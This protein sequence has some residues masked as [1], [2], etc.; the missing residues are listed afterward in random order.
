MNKLGQQGTTSDN[1]VETSN[2]E[3]QLN[4]TKKRKS[5]SSSSQV[6]KRR[7]PNQKTGW[8]G[9]WWCGQLR[10]YSWRKFPQ[11]STLMRSMH[12]WFGDETPVHNEINF[13]PNREEL[14]RARMPFWDQIEKN[15]NIP[16][17]VD[18][19]RKKV[20]AFRVGA[21]MFLIW[22]P[23]LSGKPCGKPVIKFLREG[24]MYIF[25]L[26]AAGWRPLGSSSDPNPEWTPG[27][28]KH[29]HWRHAAGPV[30]DK[31]VGA[32][33]DW[34]KI[35]QPHFATYLQANPTHMAVANHSWTVTCSNS[36]EHNVQSQ[37]VGE[38]GNGFT[39]EDI[40]KL[41][42]SIPNAQVVDLSADAV[43]NAFT[44]YD[45]AGKV[46]ASKVLIVPNALAELQVDVKTL[47][48]ELSPVAVASP[49]D[50]F[51]R[52]GIVT[53]AGETYLAQVSGVKHE[54]VTSGSGRRGMM[55]DLVKHFGHNTTVVK[56]RKR[57]CS[58]MVDQPDSSPPTFVKLTTRQDY[59]NY[60]NPND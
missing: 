1:L 31:L 22:V 42:V 32:H 47:R 25:D 21:P 55:Y 23:F 57:L 6:I 43:R 28:G 54:P 50:K 9:P 46:F 58:I 16:L 33:S 11:V 5:S 12:T 39:S 34:L 44:G 45:V 10:V 48:T 36:V 18:A 3:K 40:S 60:I 17:H 59:Q 51:S 35:L 7:S 20:I 19:E 30:L 15:T 49:P 41:A 24:T 56:Q 53:A 13:Y 38:M 14:K 27:K 52:S 8:R 37:T 4:S 26:G 2:D 29:F